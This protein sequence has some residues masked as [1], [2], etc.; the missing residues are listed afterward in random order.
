M[1]SDKGSREWGTGTLGCYRLLLLGKARREQ[2]VVELA[3]CPWSQQSHLRGTPSLELCQSPARA[4]FMQQ[5]LWTGHAGMTHTHGHPSTHSGYLFHPSV[6]VFPQ[7]MP[8]LSPVAQ[9]CLLHSCS[10][11]PSNLPSLKYTTL[12][13]LQCP[14]LCTS[15]CEV[16]RNPLFLP[17]HYILVLPTQYCSHKIYFSFEP[18]TSVSHL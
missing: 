18:S 12:P 13:D 7:V 9:F 2:E 1:C 15:S 16:C 14:L 3:G 5:G 10:S 8:Q 4:A 11:A 6:S 17:F